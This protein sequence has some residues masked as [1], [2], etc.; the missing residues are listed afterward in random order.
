MS[1]IEEVFPD[2]VSVVHADAV[3][4]G[5]A[6]IDE[7]RG[8]ELTGRRVARFRRGR[9]EIELAWDPRE[10]WLT[11]AYRPWPERPAAL[12]WTGLLSERYHSH[13]ISDADRSRL[14]A[15]LQ[16]R[17]ADVWAFGSA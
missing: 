5:F 8:E 13:G 3:T 9:A 4:R 15:T 6:L 7:R 1:S 16:S 12:E 11:L 14:R 17:L 10:H 2:F